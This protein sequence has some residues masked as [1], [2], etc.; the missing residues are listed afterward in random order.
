MKLWN[1]DNGSIVIDH[2]QLM[3]NIGGGTPVR[4]PSYGVLIEHTDGLFLFDT[5]FDMEHTERVLPFE[6]PEQ[7]AEQTIPA[8]LARCGPN[9]T[10]LGGTWVSRRG[11]RGRACGGARRRARSGCRPR[12]PGW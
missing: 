6:L 7:T 9:A 1:L 3:W 12:R 11:T 4:I 5:G 10:K 2:A 8:Q